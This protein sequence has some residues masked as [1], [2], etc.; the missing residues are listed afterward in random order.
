MRKLIT[1]FLSVLALSI[2]L[3]YAFGYDYLFRGIQLTY[4]RG[5][6][7][8]TID[9]GKFFPKN[10]IETAKPQPWQKDSLYNLKKL[11]RTLTKDLKKS[12]TASFLIIKNGK[13]LHEEYFNGYTAQTKSN[14]FSMAKALTVMLLGKAVEDKKIRNE[15]QKLSDFYPH[16]AEDD[17][18]KELTFY[19]LAAMQ[20]GLNWKED[21]KNPFLPTAKAYYGKSLAEAALHPDFKVAP[22]RKFEYQSGATQLLGFGIRKAIKIPLAYYTSQSFWKPL[23]MESPAFWTTDENNM[24]KTFCCVHA[25]PRDF[26]KLGQLLLQNGNWNGQQLLD[27]AFVQKMIRPGYLSKGAYGMGLWLNYDAPVKHYYF[28]GLYGQY[29]IIIPEKQMIIVRTGSFKDQP[30]D[31]K[32]RPLQVEFIVNET[33]KFVGE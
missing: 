7:S 4:L 20:A 12:A 30:K 14:S 5:E 6:N 2:A 24:E 13:L 8:S 3:T 10:A 18:G 32:G 28:W 27:G 31:H 11:P 25:V 19:D 29:I 17:F 21:Y 23:G 16:L 22:A 15:Y 9:D 33:V 26:A 1:V